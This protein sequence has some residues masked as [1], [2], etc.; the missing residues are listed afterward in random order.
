MTTTPQHPNEPTVHIHCLLD[1]SGSMASMAPDVV[2]GFNG[3]LANQQAQPGS[4]RMT[5][6]QFDSGDPFE[7]L[8]AGLALPRARPLGDRTFQPRGG[9]PRWA[10]VREPTPRPPG[11][12]GA[13]RGLADAP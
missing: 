3:F 10:A 12:A 2:G 6:V 1:R 11:R 7:V 13:R 8:T 4:G 9:T 5:L